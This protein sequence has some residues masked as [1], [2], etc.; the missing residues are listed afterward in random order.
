MSH[1]GCHEVA[2]KGKAFPYLMHHPNFHSTENYG[3]MREAAGASAGH[4]QA[5]GHGYGRQPLPSEQT[6]SDVHSRAGTGT[7]NGPAPRGAQGAASQ[8]GAGADAGP[9]KEPDSVRLAN[10]VRLPLIGLGTAAIKDPEIIKSALQVGYR[11]FDCAWFYGNEEIVG[12]GLAEFISAGGRDEL[13]V[14]SKVWNTHHRPE[15]VRRSVEESLSKLGCGHL[16]LLLMHWPEA[17]TPESSFSQ[18][19]TDTG[20]TISE[21]WAAMEALV[22]EGKVRALGVSN[23]SIKQVEELLSSCRIRPVVNQVELHPLNAQRKLV[24]VLFRMGLQCV[25]YSPL[26]GQSMIKPNELLNNELV[27]RV[28]KEAGKTPAQVL[29]K[30]N[31]QRGVP[32]VTKTSNPDRLAQN[33]EGMYDWKLSYEQKAALDSLDCGTRFIDFDW[34]CWADPEEGGVAKPSKVMGL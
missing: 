29:L 10:G 16:D 25:A 6:G 23:F 21:T 18:P 1:D 2:W 3:S 34:K 4:S 7:W 32:V 22:D 31:I 17:W 28:A 24:G 26:G 5:H 9:V 15:A 19:V 11:H 33:L 27:A 14:V 20:V 30:W 12:R 13:F 8:A